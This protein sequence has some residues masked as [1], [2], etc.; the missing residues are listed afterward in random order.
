M[1]NVET[2]AS[3]RCVVRPQLTCKLGDWKP[4]GPGEKQFK[5]TLEWVNKNNLFKKIKLLSPL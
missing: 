4:K 3:T 1:G 5:K 2:N